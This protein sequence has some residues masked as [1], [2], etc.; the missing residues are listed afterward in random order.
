MEEMNILRVVERDGKPVMEPGKM[1]C[2]EIKEDEILVNIKAAAINRAD[3]LQKSGKYPPPEGE[4]EIIGLEMAGEVMKCGSKSSFYK[5][6]ARV[7]GLLPGGGY[8]EYCVI[9]ETMAMPLPDSYTFE[10]GAAI[11]EVFLTAFQ[12]LI[13]LGELSEEETV[14]IHAGA[15]G[16]GSAAIQLAVQLAGATVITTSGSSEKQ[17]F[18]RSLGADLSINYKT[19]SFQKAIEKRYGK[20]RVDMIIDVVGAPHW[21]QNMEVVAMDG[22]VIYLS[23]LGGSKIEE[24][25]LTPV[26]AKRLTIKGSLLRNR[27]RA[28]KE[29]LTHNF[30]GMCMELLELNKLKPAID[31]VY[32]W[33]DVEEAHARMKE[34]LNAGKIV[35]NGM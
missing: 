10:E 28:Y 18:C 19:E 7:F 16:V 27:S 4:S 35:L 26:L 2:P 34:N 22:R 15:S 32:H 12:A 25:S 14:L 8:A 3:L 17:E 11:P 29:K 24:M 20:N 30:V 23:T 31:S 5:K 33:D 13:W 1:A 21:K 9:P 6:G